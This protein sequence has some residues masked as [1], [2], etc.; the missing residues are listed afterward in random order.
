[1]VYKIRENAINILKDDKGFFRYMLRRFFLLASSCVK[2]IILK[3]QKL[4]VF[5]E[6]I[7]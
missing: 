1:M 4:E 6:C 7:L 5:P 2:N 3:L